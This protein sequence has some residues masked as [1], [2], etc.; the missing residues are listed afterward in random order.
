[1]DSWRLSYLWDSGRWVIVQHFM[2]TI[3]D[4]D[5]TGSA[6]NNLCFTILAIG[7]FFIV[8]Y[9]NPL[10]NIHRYIEALWALNL[11]AWANAVG[12]FIVSISML[13]RR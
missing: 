4:G 13:D 6:S 3:G 7:K 12:Y 11:L 1:M 10:I 8:V 2:K 5:S 9:L